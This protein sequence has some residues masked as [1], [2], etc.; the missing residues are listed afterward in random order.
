MKQL[1]KPELEGLIRIILLLMLVPVMFVI[2]FG[3][4]YETLISDMDPPTLWELS[5]AVPFLLW[6]LYCILKKE[7]LDKFLVFFLIVMVFS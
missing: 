1:I 4:P 6:S 7:A 5:V 2:L 3:N